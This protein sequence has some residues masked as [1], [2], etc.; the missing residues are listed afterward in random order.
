MTPRSEKQYQEIRDERREQILLHAL[1][2]FTL[3]G[4]S[5]TRISDVAQSAELSQG[6][7]YRYFASK[8]DMFVAVVEQT[9]ALSNA[10]MQRFADLELSPREKMRVI[11][12]ANL[13]FRD[14]EEYARR[15]LLMFEAGLTETSPA[16][17]RELIQ[18]SFMALETIEAILSAGQESGQFTSAKDAASL[19][20]A[21]WSMIQG[22]VF[23]R[24]MNES[25]K[26][27]PVAMPD[28]ETI[29]KLFE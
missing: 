16:R 14:S 28:V 9:L 2:V 11:T 10:A 13:N 1:K 4:Y 5:G 15:Y 17:A 7:I 19:S 24:A 22:L 18:N 20:T 23:F 8:E 26:G 27:T 3:K 6:L 29:M 12:S 21:Y 25:G